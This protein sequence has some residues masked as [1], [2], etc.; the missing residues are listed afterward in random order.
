MSALAT[1]T[2]SAVCCVL[3]DEQVDEQIQSRDDVIFQL[4]QQIAAQQQQ[5][6]DLEYR[7][8]DLEGQPLQ[9]PIK[10]EEGIYITSLYILMYLCSH[11]CV[12]VCV[13]VLC[14]R[15]RSG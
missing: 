15:R 10:E 11:V 8:E 4:K 5:I 6:S 12:C 2:A 9:T 14:S 1:L 3:G 13:C 7:I